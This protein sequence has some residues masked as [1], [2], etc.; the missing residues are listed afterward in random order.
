MYKA[1][2]NI[3]YYHHLFIFLCTFL[4]INAALLL[5]KSTIRF[6]SN[7]LF[8]LNR[9]IISRP[10]TRLLSQHA[11]LNARPSR[12]LSTISAKPLTTIRLQKPVTLVTSQK[13]FTHNRGGIPPIYTALETIDIRYVQKILAQNKEQANAQGILDEYPSPLFYSMAVYT[14]TPNSH[15][16]TMENII[17]LLLEHK[18]NVHLKKKDGSTI[19]H[20]A[21]SLNLPFSI[22]KRF[23]VFGAKPNTPDNLGKS[24]FS[25]VLQKKDQNLIHL[26][27]RY[28]GK[29]NELVVRKPDLAEKKEEGPLPTL[30]PENTQNLESLSDLAGQIPEEIGTMIGYIKNPELKKR[31]NHFGVK[32]YKG[33]LLYGPPGGGKTAYA[34]AVAKESESPFF[35]IKA[36]DIK[37][38]WVG[39]TEKRIDHAFKCARK[40][41]AESK[42]KTAI[43]FF[44]EFDSFAPSR[45]N[46]HQ[47]HDIAAVNSLLAEM[48]GFKQD[49]D[50]NVIVFAA[51]NQKE[52]L[53][54]AAI[55]KGRFDTHILVELPDEKKQRQIVN[56]FLSKKP[57]E[58]NQNQQKK[59]ACITKILLLIKESSLNPSP[60]DLKSIIED[61]ARK[62]ALTPNIEFIT[63]EIIYTCTKKHCKQIASGKNVKD[64]VL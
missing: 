37:S 11:I 41:A 27:T 26:L 50:I 33:I 30:E 36:S 49:T 43:L 23:L 61:S 25:L 1:K 19:L 47:S 16:P 51:T 21:I 3:V 40:Y 4:N 18:A 53:D 60:A 8:R 7:T 13:K 28:G 22:V 52:K 56:L 6:N 39:G 15:K 42:S 48:D 55:R 12:L 35:Y 17:Q 46:L 9:Q 5:P 29:S 44:D 32:Q 34:R 63:D 20:D 24:P 31:F 62:A 14:T 58:H 10:A 45:E 57:Y 64:Y 59:D 54:K 2:K 38:K